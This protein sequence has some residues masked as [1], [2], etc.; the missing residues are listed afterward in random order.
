MTEVEFDYEG[1]KLIIQC[2][3]EEKMEDILNRFVSKEGKN[4]EEFYFM[5]GGSIVKEELTFEKTANKLDK[6]RNKMSI[7]VNRNTDI[8][9]NHDEECLKK[10]KYIICPECKESARIVV[11]NY[12]IGIYDCKNGHEISNLLIND[13]E[14]TQYYDEAKIKCQDCNVVN[15]SN[16]YNNIFFLCLNCKKNLCQICKQ[17]HDKTHNIINYENK[18]FI[19]DLHH[20]QLNSY[21]T[22]CQEDLCSNCEK[23]HSNHKIITYG[24][25]IPETKKIKKQTNSF[26]NKKEELKN[27]IKE[28]INKL[29]NL[30]NILDNYFG[31][32]QYIINNYENKNRNYFLIQNINGMIEY[33]DNIIKDINQ[34]IKEKND[35]IKVKNMINIYDKMVKENKK[36]KNKKYK[37]GKK[38]EK[39]KIEEKFKVI[40]YNE[41]LMASIEKENKNYEYQDFNIFKMKTIIKFDTAFSNIFVLK[42]G[43]ILS[44]GRDKDNKFFCFVFDLKKDK[45]FN[46]NLGNIDYIDFIIQMDDGIVIIGTNTGKLV[47]LNIKEEDYQIIKEYEIEIHKL[48]KLSKQKI[49]FESNYIL[50]IYK[51]ENKALEKEKEIKS[52]LNKIYSIQDMI[53]VNEKEIALNYYQGGLFSSYCIGFFDLDK[54]IKIQA[55]KVSKSEQKSCLINKD[56]FIYF[57]NYNL[58]PVDLK[59][60]KRKKEF[61]L[62]NEKRVESILSLNDNKF[63]VAQDDYLNQF[64]VKGDDYELKLNC[65]INLRFWSI[66][67]YINGTLL[68]QRKE[69]LYW[70]E[71]NN[72]YYEISG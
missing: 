62:P 55:Y 21:C 39:N 22:D 37:L 38:K 34:I 60:H 5:Y 44:Y 14:Q 31:I 71:E 6:E 25:I 52:S 56:L 42:D 24:S 69:E 50:N 11:E 40:E 15:K 19:C 9:T 8:D 46:I 43:R 26:N 23:N 70:D 63:L 36:D 2:N 47:L 35:G 12:Q 58:Y 66:L 41:E 49:I 18:Y 54:D 17:K 53:V 3:P 13:F 7:L 32:Y 33:T 1:R 27:E 4:K 29:N 68:I 48:C 10:S 45:Y 20:E 57:D 16:T 65:I 51:Y 64:E 28:T 72:D 30:M 59:N 67:K 61:I